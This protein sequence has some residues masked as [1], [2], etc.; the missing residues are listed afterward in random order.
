MDSNN[1]S[2]TDIN[3]ENHDKY[4]LKKIDNYQP[5]DSGSDMDISDDE[6]GTIC[7]LQEKE[8]FFSDICTIDE[9][10][11]RDKENCLSECVNRRQTLDLSTILEDVP[12]NGLEK[13]NVKNKTETS[14][15]EKDLEMSFLNNE[16]E[17]CKAILKDDELLSD[18]LL[19]LCEKNKDIFNEEDRSYISN[20]DIT[21][22]EVLVQNFRNMK[23]L[24]EILNKR[25]DTEQNINETT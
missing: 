24:L 5:E 17:A 14:R 13:C 20:G 23:N 10:I 22:F 2:C 9:I 18:K 21:P 8:V 25:K 12:S 11:D 15:A 3:V 16:I 4:S 19:K 6:A 7:T 1:I